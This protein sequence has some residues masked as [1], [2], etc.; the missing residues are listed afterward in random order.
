MPSGLPVAV[1]ARKKAIIQITS[2]TISSLCYL[3]VAED[4]YKTSQN[5]LC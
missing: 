5:G 1:P 2:V 4:Q 3:V